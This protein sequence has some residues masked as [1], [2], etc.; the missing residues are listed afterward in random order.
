MRGAERQQWQHPRTGERVT[1][2]LGS[3]LAR[4]ERD[5]EVGELQTALPSHTQTQKLAREGF[6][7]VTARHPDGSLWLPPVL[8]PY[9]A[10][11]EASE[12]PVVR[13]TAEPGHEP[14]RWDSK[15]G[16]VPYRPRGAA[17]P[18]ALDGRP[19][20]FLAQLNFAQLNP[21]GLALPDFP[22]EGILQFFILN[23]EFYG[24]DMESSMNLDGAQKHY[25]VL[26][27]PQVHEDEAALDASV[28]RPEYDPVEVAGL[29]ERGYG[30]LIDDSY[31]IW[32]K[33]PYDWDA[34]EEETQFPFHP[35]ALAFV[36]DREPVSGADEG[37]SDVMGV[38][39]H[40]WEDKPVQAARSALY[41]LSPG[42]HKV[43]GYPDFTQS[44]PRRPEDNLTLLFQLDSDARLGLL[45]GDTGTA[46]FFIRPADLRARNFSRVAYNWDC[47]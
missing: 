41:D 25:R 17:W 34:L 12:R 18:T 11:L 3:G 47:G 43:G 16:G 42:G 8:E 30:S 32:D 7:R 6:V 10:A 2:H 31:L 15:V 23:A 28:P 35:R 29:R 27:W 44:D 46:N 5:G 37:A 1:L 39:L 24:A 40:D 13:V 21:G 38:N 9:R 26:Y 45:W 36:P 14:K 19:L 4:L 20:V 33:L 22:G